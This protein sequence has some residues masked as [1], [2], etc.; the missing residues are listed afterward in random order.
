MYTIGLSPEEFEEF[1][2]VQIRPRA[3]WPA[4]FSCNQYQKVWPFRSYGYTGP[5]TDIQGEIPR[6]DEIVEWV[7]EM[8]P[9]GG[10]FFI[11]DEGVFIKPEDDDIQIAE[12]VVG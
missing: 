2:D 5:V 1:R 6:L 4:I 9:E 8:R 11:N 10:R 12:F 7:L 3:D